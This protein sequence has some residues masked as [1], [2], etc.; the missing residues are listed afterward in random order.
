MTVTF[1]T[2]SRA[3]KI[4]R[5]LA[6]GPVP[7]EDLLALAP[8]RNAKKNPHTIAALQ[9]TGLVGFTRERGYA[10]TADGVDALDRLDCGGEVVR[11]DPGV[12]WSGPAK[13]SVRIFSREAAA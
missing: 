11:H 6:H 3:H 9:R 1:C 12:P 8:R 13:P 2:G 7:R 4:L 5:L 10:L